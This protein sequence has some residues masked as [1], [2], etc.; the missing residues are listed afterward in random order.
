[1]L[2]ALILSYFFYVLPIMA[3]SVKEEEKNNNKKNILHTISNQGYDIAY[4]CITPKHENITID[5]NILF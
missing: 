5:E 1:M 2:G 3:W 4:A